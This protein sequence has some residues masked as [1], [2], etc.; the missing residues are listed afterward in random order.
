M[1]KSFCL[2]FTAAMLIAAS[3]NVWADD[4]LTNTDESKQSL[5]AYESY[6]KYYKGDDLMVGKDIPAGNYVLFS[7]DNWFAS[8]LIYQYGE[9]L[10]TSTGDKKFLSVSYPEYTDIVRLSGKQYI[11]V[12]GGALVPEDLVEKLDITRNGSFKVGRDIPSGHYTFKLDPS[13]LTGYIEIC[14]LA[15]NAET[16]VYKLY[17]DNSQVTLKLDNGKILK[18]YSVDIYDSNLKMYA[19]YS[20]KTDIDSNTDANL[21]FS[22]IRETY[23]N[24][25]ISEFS[26]Y[27]KT[28]SAGSKSSEKYKVTY[29]NSTIAAWKSLA[30]NDAERR[31]G[32]VTGDMFY[33]FYC[34]ALY[35]TP[36]LC[37]AKNVVLYNLR[38]TGREYKKAFEADRDS[39]LKL[40]IEYS[41]LDNF[42][43]C[44]L[45]KYHMFNLYY[46][47]P[48]GYGYAV[49]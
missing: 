32:A 8:K 19:D 31:Y 6:E 36:A 16:K 13:S 43:D 22:D 12:S 10:S 5:S 37:N 18:K 45:Y 39:Y 30:V 2:L 35:S 47:V 25:I 46:S 41:A 1:K 14:N 26:D 27:I 28:Y 23:K 11:S 42:K 29:V 4:P 9:T 20:P 3:L 38:M 49:S 7:D 15:D 40:L 34:F 44:E 33:R 21:N 48:K 24:K 17:E